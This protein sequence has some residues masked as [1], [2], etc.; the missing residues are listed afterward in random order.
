MSALA[1]TFWLGKQKTVD[2][3]LHPDPREMWLAAFRCFPSDKVFESFHA[4]MDDNEIINDKAHARWN[5]SGS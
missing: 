2:A 4:D 5:I 3:D 1:R